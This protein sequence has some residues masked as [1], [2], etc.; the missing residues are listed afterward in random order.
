[1][2]FAI[3]VMDATDAL[4]MRLANYQLHRDHLNSA[5]ITIVLAG[6]LSDTDGQPE[7]SMFVV[8]AETRQEVEAF[9][10]ADPFYLLQ[11]WDLTTLKA[12]PLVKRRGW[13]DGY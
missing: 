9:Y 10:S 1:M 6:P 4:P 12:N 3:H 2:L 5:S 11:V 13:L 7:G 8:D